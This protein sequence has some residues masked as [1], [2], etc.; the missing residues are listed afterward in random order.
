MARYSTHATFSSMVSP[1]LRETHQRSSHP[2]MSAAL[3]PL[4]DLRNFLSRLHS[5][6]AIFRGL[7]LSGSMQHLFASYASLSRSRRS[8]RTL[9][10]FSLS[11]TSSEPRYMWLQKASHVVFL[12]VL[13]GP[14]SR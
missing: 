4:W 12:L 1:T 7:S 11:C 3:N 13:P 5:W 10:D 8:A 2:W 14:S 9:R 6:L